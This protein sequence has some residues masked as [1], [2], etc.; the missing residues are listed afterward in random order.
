M[1]LW[2]KNLGIFTAVA[3]VT[4]VAWI[5]PW[6][7]SFCKLQLQ[8]KKAPQKLTKNTKRQNKQKHQKAKP[9]LS[10]IYSGGN[11]NLNTQV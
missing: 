4:A 5:H 9:K 7:R 3:R 11:P 1:A 6:P 2:A 8:P 10:L